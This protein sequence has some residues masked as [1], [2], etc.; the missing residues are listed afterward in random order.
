MRFLYVIVGALVGGLG[1]IFAGIFVSCTWVYPTSNVC[2][3]WGLTYTAPV[4]LIGGAV[5]GWLMSRRKRP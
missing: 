1:C 5:C 2:G 3:I 4:G